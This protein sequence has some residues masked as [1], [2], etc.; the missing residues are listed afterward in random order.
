MEN[1]RLDM[2]NGHFEQQNASYMS[3]HGPASDDDIVIVSYARTA[4]TRAKKGAQANTSPEL[5][6]KPVLEAVIKEAGLKPSQV[7][8][9]TIGNVLQGGSGAA[10]ARMGQFL[11]GVPTETPLYV[12]N[13]MCSSGL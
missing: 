4:M 7:E 13:R 2:L 1:T 8:E 12:I 5:M 9:I 3:P 6:L 10:S 11:A